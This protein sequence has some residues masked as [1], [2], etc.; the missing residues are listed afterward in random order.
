[1]K[2]KTNFFPEFASATISDTLTCGVFTAN[3][4]ETY[5]ML[6]TVGSW[7]SLFATLGGTLALSS[8]NGGTANIGVASGLFFALLL[9]VHVASNFA[10]VRLTPY[11]MI[12][13]A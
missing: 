9:A 2:V 4:I 12:K 13:G 6:I 3:S 1:M 8:P 10:G 11:V 5:R 7:L